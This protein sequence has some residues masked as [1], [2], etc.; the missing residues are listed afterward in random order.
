MFCSKCGKEQQEGSR[1]CAQ[2]G[3]EIGKHAASSTVPQKKSGLQDFG[4]MAARTA[5]ESVKSQTRSQI[6]RVVGDIFRTIFK[7]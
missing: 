4:E 7:R 3:Q 5:A 2:C 6:S 1:F